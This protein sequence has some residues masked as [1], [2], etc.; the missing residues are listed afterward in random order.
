[1]R[2]GWPVVI[3]LVFLGGSLADAGEDVAEP[4]RVRE[5][6]AERGRLG[7]RS[8]WNPPFWSLRAY[9]EAWR[10]WGR[11][12][13]PEDYPRAF[14]ERYGL[15]EAPYENGGL[16]A[17]FTRPKGL[18]G[19]GQGLGNDCLLCHAGTVAGRT[20]IGLG[21]TSLDMQSLYEELAAADKMDP[22]M[23]LRLCNVRGTNEASNFA[24][25]LMQFRDPELRYRVPVKYSLCENLCEDVPAWW[26][27][28]KKKT[29]YHLGLADQRSV[30]TLMPFLLI[31]GNSAGAIRRREPDFA[32]IR[33]YL[34]SLEPPAYPFAI[35]QG[36]AARGKRVFERS[37]ARCHG[38][39]GP[40]GNYPSKLVPLEV[41]G[42]DATLAQ[43]FD[44][45]GVAHY[46]KSWFAREAGPQGERYHGLGGGGYQAPPLDGIWATAPYLHNGSVPT[47]YHLLDS[48]ERPAIFTRSY[49]GDVDEY[50]PARL[51]LKVR[52]LDSPPDEEAP[53]IER[54]KVY[55]T[56]QPGRGNGG[57]T[58]G[59]R[60]SEPERSAVIEYL[61]TL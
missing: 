39:Y 4:G 37:C 61:K 27:Y 26:L 15:H 3:A 51:G 23:P 18:L 17:G 49:R 48:R 8:P 46:L 47:V 1:M 36:L 6:S 53:A 60:L 20:I 14:R 2:R 45:L 9:A 19:V 31:P 5:P 34:L 30:R 56:R 59:D 22:L 40:D 43:A 12:D 44:P 25:Y 10:Q 55:D 32:D 29:I 13:R 57:H 38:T 7:V 24:I 58:F 52:R 41:V 42:T 28:R 35:D 33:A 11:S 21:N 54:R 16:P 50:D